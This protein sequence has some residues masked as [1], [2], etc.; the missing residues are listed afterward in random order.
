MRAISGIALASLCLSAT[1][2]A[3]SV[4]FPLVDLGYAIHRATGYNVG[5]PINRQRRMP[6][7]NVLDCRRLLQLQQRPLCITSYW[8]QSLPHPPITINRPHGSPGRHGR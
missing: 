8:R 1:I 7:A 3:G 6:S 2:K 4:Y 5:P